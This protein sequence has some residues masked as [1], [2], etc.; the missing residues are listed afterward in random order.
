MYLGGIDDI[1]P[2]AAAARAEDLSGL[3]PAYTCV[4]ELDPFRDE[5]ITYVSRLVRAG[6]PVEFHLYPGCFHGFDAIFNDS[7][8]SRQAREEYIR[9]L[10]RAIRL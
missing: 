4:G 10:A 2:Y 9:A 7:E 6:V 5:T 8:I 3:P 1:S